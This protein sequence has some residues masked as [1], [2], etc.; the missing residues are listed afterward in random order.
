MTIM[1][2]EQENKDPNLKFVRAIY[3][4][5][6]NGGDEPNGILISKD[7][8]AS[9]WEKHRDYMRSHFINAWD[10]GSTTFVLGLQVEDFIKKFNLWT[11]EDGKVINMSG[12]GNS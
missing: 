1:T 12:V 3:P 2:I 9:L 4:D 10:A 8:Y 6:S 5:N 7:L 11:E